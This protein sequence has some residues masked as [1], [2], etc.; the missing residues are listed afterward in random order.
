VTASWVVQRGAILELL[1]EP[2]VP[3]PGS[4]VVV[5]TDVELEESARVVLLDLIATRGAFERLSMRTSV[6]SQARPIVHDFSE[7]RPSS[8]DVRAVGTLTIVGGA[9]SC[10]DKIVA[11]LDDVADEHE[12]VRLGIGAL[13]DDRG[14][15]VRAL[16][17]DVW[18]IRTALH[19][20]RTSHAAL[21][22]PRG[23]RRVEA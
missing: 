17:D 1:G 9:G 13:R 2:I 22:L 4:D 18:A 23:C 20:L 12:D 5:A 11:A 10:G 6:R 16:S 14:V 19:A 21:S 7:I 3:F 15:L 8:L